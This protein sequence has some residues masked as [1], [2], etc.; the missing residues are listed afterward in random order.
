M[1][2]MLHG[3]TTHIAPIILYLRI[4]YRCMVNFMLCPYVPKKEPLVPTDQ[5]AG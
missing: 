5:E 4:I 3:D 2:H 1:V